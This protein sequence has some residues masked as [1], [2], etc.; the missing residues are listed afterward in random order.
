M[1]YQADTSFYLL[2]IL[3]IA[4]TIIMKAEI[5]PNI[6]AMMTMV[7]RAVMEIN[8]VDLFCKLCRSN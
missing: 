2:F 6:K 1:G 3:E 5:I 7:A 8:I 4:L